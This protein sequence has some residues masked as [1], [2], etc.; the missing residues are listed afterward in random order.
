M[1]KVFVGNNLNRTPVMV[2]EETTLRK[3]LEDNHI[4]YS[5]GMTSL[6]GATLQAGDLDKTFKEF[7]VKETC[8][9]LNT[10]KAVNA[11]TIKVV[12]QTAVIE[13]GF[14]PEEI[15]EVAK[16]RGRVLTLVDTDTKE[17]VFAVALSKGKGCIN[18]NGAEFGAGASKDGKAIITLDIPVGQD[19]KKYLEESVG[20]SILYLQKIEE[21]IPAALESIKA[22]K[23][24][25]L[26]TIQLV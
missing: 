14:T 10:A 25:V 19:A 8:Y 23:D 20:V 11:A 13:S 24:K 3:V 4:D 6:D 18:N 21:G 7:N 9:L 15:A 12:G 2:T 1:I 17:P 22:E 5:I 26:G 16:Y